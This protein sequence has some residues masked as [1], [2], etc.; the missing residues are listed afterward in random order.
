MLYLIKNNPTDQVDSYELADLTIFALGRDF[1]LSGNSSELFTGENSFTFGLSDF[2]N[3]FNTAST[4]INGTY[5]PV[6]VT[7]NPTP[8]TIS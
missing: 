6:T 4:V 1:T 5:Q 2:D 8:E 3:T 7:S